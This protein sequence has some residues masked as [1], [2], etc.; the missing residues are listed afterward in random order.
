MN[1]KLK[2]ATDI[3]PLDPQEEIASLKAEIINLK[4]KI[5]MLEQPA[6]PSF[7]GRKREFGRDQQNGI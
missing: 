7:R 5:E 6:K 1:D 2:G 4:A 3:K